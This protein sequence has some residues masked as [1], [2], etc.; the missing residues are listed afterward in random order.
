M[1]RQVESLDEAI[2]D[3]IMYGGNHEKEV[4]P[5]EEEALDGQH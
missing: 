1:D 5:T 4:E 2:F 3:E